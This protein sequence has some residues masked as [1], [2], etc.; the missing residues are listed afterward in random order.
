MCIAECIGLVFRQ[1][2]YA[3]FANYSY[4]YDTSLGRSCYIHITYMVDSALS[5]SRDT[6][7]RLYIKYI[8]VSSAKSF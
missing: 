4:I 7:L 8:S 2:T 6:R 3:M 1:D 5:L